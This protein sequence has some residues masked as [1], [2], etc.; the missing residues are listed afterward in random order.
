M[1]NR[2]WIN[3]AQYF[4]PD[5]S[6]FSLIEEFDCLVVV[7]PETIYSRKHLE[8]DVIDDSFETDKDTLYCYHGPAP[9]PSFED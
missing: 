3:D 5:S 6:A 8:T 2:I 4:V 1:G 9:S 7:A